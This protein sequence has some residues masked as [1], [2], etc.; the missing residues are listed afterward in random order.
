LLLRPP[1]AGVSA[2][3]S[4]TSKQQQPTPPTG[5]QPAAAAAGPSDTGKSSKRVA[6]AAAAGGR[7]KRTKCQSLMFVLIPLAILAVLGGVGAAIGITMSQQR[8]AVARSTA[9]AAAPAAA[10]AAVPAAAAGPGQPLA[11]KVNMSLPPD[12]DGSPAPSCSELFS[13]KAGRGKLEVCVADPSLLLAR[14]LLLS[15]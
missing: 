9:A 6:A 3:D 4:K 13:P 14:S 2:Y 8:A 11:F 1:P 5:D 10:P 15:L 12:P 7:K